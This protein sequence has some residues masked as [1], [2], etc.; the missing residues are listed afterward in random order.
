MQRFKNILVVVNDPE[1]ERFVAKLAISLTEN[2]NGTMTIAT[3]SERL[4]DQIKEKLKATLKLYF[5]RLVRD[6]K[7][8]ILEKFKSRFCKKI[9]TEMKLLTGIAF[10][11]IIRELIRR[12]HDIILVHSE[13]HTSLKG[14]ILG[15]TEL[16]LLRKYPAP[17]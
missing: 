15:S 16:R 10:I 3:I 2:N 13:D 6:E 11:E 9:Q 7:L 1:R 4:S 5:E 8:E 14:W 17:S 12:K